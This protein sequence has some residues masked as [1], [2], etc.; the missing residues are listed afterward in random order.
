MDGKLFAVITR[1][2]AAHRSGR[3]ALQRVGA[4]AIGGAFVFAGLTGGWAMGQDT[5]QPVVLDPAA[6]GPGWELID[7]QEVAATVDQPLALQETE[8]A[9]PQGA[10]V[11]VELALVEPDPEHINDF[12]AMMGNRA[13][14]F[15]QRADLLVDG[16]ETPSPTDVCTRGGVWWQGTDPLLADPAIIGLC[17]LGDGVVATILANGPTDEIPDLAGQIAELLKAAVP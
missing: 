17:S 15:G 2:L 7:Q 9:G 1:A 11:A 13:A 14:T 3:H 6:I 5:Q 4:G 16:A 12:A 8:Y 10:R